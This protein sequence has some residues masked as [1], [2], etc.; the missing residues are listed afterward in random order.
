MLFYCGIDLHAKKSVLCIIDT[1]DTIQFRDKI[2]NQIN[3]ILKVL[4]SF[5][6]K[7]KVAV[8]ATLN[9]YRLVDGLQ[10]AGFEVK[11][12]HP[13][14]LQVIKKAKVKTDN[15]DAFH[16]AR[17]VIGAVIIKHKL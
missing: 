3:H 14:G 7:P 11:L 2:P 15:R 5:T 6:P 4:N 9:W 12:A 13:F 8:E 17:L 16:L 1:Q 10:E